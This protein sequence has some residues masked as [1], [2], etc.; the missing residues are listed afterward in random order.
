MKGSSVITGHL[1]GKDIPEAVFFDLS[2]VEIG[3]EVIVIGEDSTSLTFR[4]VQ[5]RA[6]PHNASTEE[7][8]ISNDGKVRLNLITCGGDWLSSEELYAERTVVFTELVTD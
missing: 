6:F 4:V 8:F 5:V 3:D 7:V 1:N 2:Q